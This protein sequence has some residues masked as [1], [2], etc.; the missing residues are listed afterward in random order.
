MLDRVLSCHVDRGGED[1]REEREERE[2]EMV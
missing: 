2:R 1:M